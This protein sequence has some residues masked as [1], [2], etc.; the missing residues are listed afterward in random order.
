[1]K[2]SNYFPPLTIEIEEL[3]KGLEII[4]QSIDAVVKQTKTDYCISKCEKY[5]Y[6]FLYG[7]NKYESCSFRSNYRD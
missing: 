6:S 7:G 3:K 1:M 4:E 2:C 5:Y